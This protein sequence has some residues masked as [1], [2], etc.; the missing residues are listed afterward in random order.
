[1]FAKKRSL[2]GNESAPFL[3]CLLPL[4]ADID[5]QS[6]LVIFKTCDPTAT[7]EQSLSGVTHIA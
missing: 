7:I 5:P 2:G 4:N 1:M 6:A 3:V